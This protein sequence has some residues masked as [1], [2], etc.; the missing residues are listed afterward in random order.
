MGVLHGRDLLSSKYPTAIIIDAFK[1]MH[2][3]PLKNPIG[4]YFFAVINH[5]LYAFDTKGDSYK[6]RQ[7]LAK[8]FEVL[9][10]F[11]DHYK[12]LSPH[13][14][15]LELIT[16]KNHLPKMSIMLYKVMSILKL[17]E[18]RQFEA[19]K[20]KELIDT[21]SKEKDDNPQRYEQYKDVITYL[22]DLEI[23]EIVTPVRRVSSYLDESFMA[24][25]PKF[26]GSVKTAVQLALTENREVNHVPVTSKKGWV[27]ILAI[28]MAI[29]LVGAILYMVY[30]QG[31][32]DGI[33]EV[34]D[35]FNAVGDAFRSASTPPSAVSVDNLAT[36]YPTPES[37]KAAIDRGDVKLSDFPP[38][39]QDLIKNVE[40]PKASP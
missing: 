26:M 28:M 19:F 15:E 9:I 20:I 30:D 35:S 31:H 21:L 1:T 38:N 18:K 34:T 11:T 23:D 29:G 32:F 25:D 12:P 37:A 2:F 5:E 16:E 40:T 22:Q 10:Y 13:I 17:K 27:K 14:K 39:I 6:W 33:F 4:D 36:K 8:T 3:V 7:N 24:T